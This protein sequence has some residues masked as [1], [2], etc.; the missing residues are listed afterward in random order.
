MKKCFA[1]LFLAIV[2]FIGCS[3]DDD[4]RN[5]NPYLPSYNFSINIDMSLNQY[6]SLQF[7]GNAVYANQAGAGINDIIIM[8]TG[9]G[10]TAFEATC[11]NQPITTCSFMEIDGINAICPCDDAEYSLFTGLAPGK[12]Y[13]LKPYRITVVSPT[14]IRVSN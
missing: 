9:S 10:F 6:A 2:V 5:N 11:P 4:N 13:S 3:K 1:V 12:Q 7:T 14:Y 8:N